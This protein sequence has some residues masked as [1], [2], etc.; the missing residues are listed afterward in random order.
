[1][2]EKERDLCFWKNIFLFNIDIKKV[3]IFKIEIEMG[4]NNLCFWIFSSWIVKNE[5]KHWA[6]VLVEIK[7]IKSTQMLSIE[8][9]RK[10]FQLNTKRNYVLYIFWIKTLSKN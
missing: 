9:K 5:V 6:M 8:S 4:N 1:M 3:D 10:S 2:N 7:I